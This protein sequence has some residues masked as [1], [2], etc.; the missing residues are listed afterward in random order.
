MR[1]AILDKLHAAGVEI[2]SPTLMVQRPAT[3]GERFIPRARPHSRRAAEFEV[4]PEDLVFDKADEAAMLSR[5]LHERA[6]LEEHIKELHTSV[7]K[8]EEAD[9][10][11]I[12]AELAACEKRA[13]ELAADI[14][15]FRGS[16]NAG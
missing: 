2:A 14:D 15:A 12:E 3:A 5:L 10:S 7:R 8:A 9:R 16:K 4:A 1:R 6:D 13:E 11:P